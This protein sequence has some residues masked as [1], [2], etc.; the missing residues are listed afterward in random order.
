MLPVLLSDDVKRQDA[1]ASERGISVEQLMENAGW[2]V[3]R[4][5][6]RLLGGTYGRRVVIVCGKGNN[7]GD[8]LVAGRILAGEG[9]H[10]TAVL[11]SD[12]HSELTAL[13]LRRFPGRVVGLDAMSR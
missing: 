10:A 4:A 2:A 1:S 7:A 3:A 13:N 9:A 6:R 8:G 5:A 12:K 11:T